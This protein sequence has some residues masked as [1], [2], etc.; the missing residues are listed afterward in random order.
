VTKIRKLFYAGIKC[1]TLG[2][3]KRTGETGSCKKGLYSSGR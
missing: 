2:K 1:G 3:E